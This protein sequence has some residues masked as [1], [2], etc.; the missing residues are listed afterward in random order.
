MRHWEINCLNHCVDIVS[1]DEPIIRE[2]DGI[3][4][5][6]ISIKPNSCE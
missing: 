1:F 5:E 4:E 3:E 2:I 6:A